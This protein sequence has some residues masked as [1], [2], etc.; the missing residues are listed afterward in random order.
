MTP[1]TKALPTKVKCEFESVLNLLSSYT[2]RQ[3]HV[4]NFFFCP[5]FGPVFP[6]HLNDVSTTF[7][8]CKSFG[9]KCAMR[10]GSR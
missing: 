10:T 9:S 8:P 4:P 5:G 3:E 7:A 6:E 1:A 2:Y